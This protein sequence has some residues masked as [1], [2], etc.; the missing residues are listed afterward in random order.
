M[1]KKL[2]IVIFCILIMFV[3]AVPFIS[4][5]QSGRTIWNGVYSQDQAAQGESLMGQCRGCHGASMD[6]GQAPGVDEFL[7]EYRRPAVNVTVPL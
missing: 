2:G 5:R 1:A 7:A 3:L 6:G 4:A